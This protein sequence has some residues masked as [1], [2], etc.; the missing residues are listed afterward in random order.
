[1]L[2]S[3]N[4]IN[5]TFAADCLKP[6]GSLTI[7]SVPAI[8]K[9]AQQYQKQLGKLVKFDLADASNNDTAGL[10]WLINFKAGLKKSG[11]ALQLINVPDSLKKLSKLSD[12][13]KLLEIE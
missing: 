11:K 7:E 2:K 13:D 5:L 8:D 4:K 9:L 10:A 3:V 1:M 12:A 6:D